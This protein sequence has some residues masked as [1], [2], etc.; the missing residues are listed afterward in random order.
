MWVLVGTSKIIDCLLKYCCWLL[1]VL[2]DLNA[3]EIIIAPTIKYMVNLFRTEHFMIIYWMLWRYC[4]IRS[5]ILA[6]KHCLGVCWDVRVRDLNI[7]WSNLIFN[8]GSE[9]SSRIRNFFG[10]NWALENLKA[11]I[12]HFICSGTDGAINKNGLCLGEIGILKNDGL[13]LHLKLNY[14]K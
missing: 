1:I 5:L 12:G 8:N 11:L 13:I 3:L 9:A 2:H 6:L 14:L 10:V 4:A 7:L